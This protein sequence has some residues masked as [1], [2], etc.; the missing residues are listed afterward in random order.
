[1]GV[2]PGIGPKRVEALAG[3]GVRTLEELLRYFPRA[4]SDRR[5]MA[6]IADVAEGDVVTVEATVLKSRHIRMRGRMSMAEITVSD[7]SGELKATFFGRGFLARAFSEDKRVVLTGTVSQY[8]G[9]AIKNPEYEILSGDEE[10]RLNTGCI[11]PVYP[12]AEN[13][14]QRYLRRWI[15]SALDAV[16]GESVDPLP[17]SVRRE[18]GFPPL[19]SALRSIHFPKS[20]EEA[21]AARRRVIYEELFAIQL[22]VLKARAKRRSEPNQRRHVVDGPTLNAFTQSLPFPLTAA[23]QKA[24]DEILADMEASWPMARLIQG[25]VGC[26]KTVVA[27]HAIAAARDGGFQSA[28]MAP[29]EI[30]AEQ[31]HRTMKAWLD[32]LGIRVALLTGSTKGAAALRGSIA[33]GDIDLVIGTHALIQKATGFQRLGLV[34]VDE[35][36]RFGVAQRLALTQKGAQPDILHMTATPI[37]RSLALTVYGAMDLTLIDELPPGRTPVTTRKVIP[38][39]EAAVYNHIKKAAGQGFQAYVVCPLVEESEETSLRAATAHFEDLANGVLAGLRVGLIHGRMPGPAK[40]EIM[41]RFKAGDIDILL[42]TTVI[43]VGVDVPNA[44]TMVIEDAAQFGLTQLHQLR[45]RVGRGANESRCYLLGKTKTPE[46]RKR[47]DI[48]CETNDGFVIAEEDLKL[49]GSG[50]IYGWK[51]SGLGDL[52]MADLTRDARL[53]ALAR[54]DAEVALQS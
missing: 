34:I 40:E 31:H 50:E 6:R 25:D 54:E 13:V 19:G 36:H 39:K 32:P 37:P 24:V 7:G 35:Q 14:T 33:E 45:G 2:L 41:N 23:Q 46:G 10:D 29:T 11:V 9:L 5:S 47:L 1:M 26:G 17:E 51:Q 53:L 20:E 3:V 28:V 8:Q 16:S 43:E 22:Q 49:R 21:Q 38:S 30:L 27:V 18:R 44:T 48:L 15:R 42:S 12:L 4:Y 52:R